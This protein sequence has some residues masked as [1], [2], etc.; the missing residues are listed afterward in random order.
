MVTVTDDSTRSTRTY[1]K[2]ARLESGI[3]KSLLTFLVATLDYSQEPES[4]RK[5]FYFRFHI[6]IMSSEQRVIKLINKHRL[7]IKYSTT[8]ADEKQFL[9]AKVLVNFI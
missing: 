7:F 6:S 3:A 8:S 9:L 4:A 5:I 2:R 1:G